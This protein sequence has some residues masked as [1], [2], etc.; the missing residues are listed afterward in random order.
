MINS[1]AKLSIKK[2]WSNCGGNYCHI[3]YENNT[4]EDVSV[5]VTGRVW[6]A[7]VSDERISD[8]S[9]LSDMIE[10]RNGLKTCDIF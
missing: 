2:P 9:V 3:R 7:G 5:S 10:I 4:H 8:V 1:V 6:Q